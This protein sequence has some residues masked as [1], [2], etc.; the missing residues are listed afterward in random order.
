MEGEWCVAYHGVGCYRELNEVKDITG[1]IIVGG[2]KKDPRQAHSKCDDVFH[3]GKK[4]GEGIYCTPLIK[5]AE[6]Y[7]GKSQINGIS[8]KIVLMVRVKP[9]A[10][11]KCVCQN[12]FWVVNGTYDEIRPYRILYKKDKYKYEDD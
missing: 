4:V 3:R 12:D 5:I 8:Y 11:R 7:A 2:F 6:E 9:H 10:I 1:K